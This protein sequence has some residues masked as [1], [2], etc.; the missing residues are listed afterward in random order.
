[1]FFNL[2]VTGISCPV[3]TAPNN[4]TIE[5][6]LG[7]DGVANKGDKCTFHCD[8]GFKLHGSATRKCIALHGRA[9]W[10]GWKAVCSEGMYICLQARVPATRYIAWH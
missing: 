7:D 2:F 8:D 1:V 6:S 9:V 5:C 4:G 3:L 10:S